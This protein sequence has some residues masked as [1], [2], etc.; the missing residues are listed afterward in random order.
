[1]TEAEREL[2]Y[3]VAETVLELIDAPHIAQALRTVENEHRM[4]MEAEPASMGHD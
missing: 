2:L 3:L 1:M 4:K